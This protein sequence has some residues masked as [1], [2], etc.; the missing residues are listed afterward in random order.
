MTLYHKASVSTD[1]VLIK[2]AEGSRGFNA[3]QQ[4]LERMSRERLG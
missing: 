4:T 1:R 2:L 3:D